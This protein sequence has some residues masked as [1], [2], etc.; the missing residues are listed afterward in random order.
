MQKWKRG[1]G[2]MLYGVF[3][4]FL[5]LT[6]TLF[7][8]QTMRLQQAHLDAQTAADSISDA[9]AV[10]ASNES[11]DYNDVQKYA[12]DVQKKVK[13]QT[14]VDTTNLTIDKKKLEDDNQV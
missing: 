4:M 2:I 5:V 1:S 10:Y 7:F 3:I 8:S 9:T 12:K 6:M 13:E 11:S 14:G